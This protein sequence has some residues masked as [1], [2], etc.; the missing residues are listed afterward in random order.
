MKKILAALLCLSMTLSEGVQYWI[1]NN[2]RQDFFLLTNISSYISKQ[3]YIKITLDSENYN[4][5]KKNIVVGARTV[6]SCGL[7]YTYNI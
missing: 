5:W 3:D 4:F 6:R 2:K 7:S 1:W